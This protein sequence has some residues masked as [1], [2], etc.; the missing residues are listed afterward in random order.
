MPPPDDVEKYLT[1]LGVVPGGA[2]AAQN[3]PGDLHYS[4]WQR[5]ASAAKQLLK[6]QSAAKSLQQQQKQQQKQLGAAQGRYTP[7]EANAIRLVLT[8]VQREMTPRQI[9]SLLNHHYLARCIY[10]QVTKQRKSSQAQDQ[11]LDFL[12]QP[13][14]LPSTTQQP[15]MPQQQQQQPL[16]VQTHVPGLLVQ[17]HSDMLQAL[18]QRVHERQANT[19]AYKEL[20]SW[21]FFLGRYPT[22]MTTVLKV[23]NCDD[24]SHGLEKCFW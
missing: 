20:V 23:R 8:A 16:P 24:V 10:Q 6:R 5:L 21:I 7:Q 22:A 11:L 2:P 1:A 18:L 13:G 12:K 17:R 9:K 3:Q 14:Q 15:L 19:L 4:T